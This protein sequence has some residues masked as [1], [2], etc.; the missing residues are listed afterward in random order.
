[1]GSSE[2]FRWF[3]VTAARISSLSPALHVNQS[4]IEDGRSGDPR[5]AQD[6]LEL[7]RLLL[8]EAPGERSLVIPEE[9]Y[10]DGFDLLEGLGALSLAVDTDQ[11]QGRRK[12]DGTDR[13]DRESPR[14]P[15][16]ISRGRHGR[17]RRPQTHHLS[18]A[19]RIDSHSFS[20]SRHACVGQTRSI[21]CR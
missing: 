12:G 8:R 14:F 1:M 13:G 19:I 15:V 6:A 11:P 4:I 10:R 18:E 21:H 16:P 5:S 3:G 20:S 17:P 2:S 9:V 7:L